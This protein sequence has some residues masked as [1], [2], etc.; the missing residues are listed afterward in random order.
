MTLPRAIGM[1][2]LIAGV[3]GTAVYVRVQRTR[4]AHEIHKMARQES[5]LRRK[6][7]RA[8]ADI[9]ELRA[10]QRLRDR[11]SQMQLSALPPEIRALPEPVAKVTGKTGLASKRKR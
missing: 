10:P 4:T 2:L 5:E 8:N 9:A 7:D 1:I 3:A 11:A 6:I